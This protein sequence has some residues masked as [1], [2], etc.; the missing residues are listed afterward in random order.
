[1]FWE[2]IQIRNSVNHANDI[3][4]K[5][6]L[7]PFVRFLQERLENDAS[8]SP[9]L[10]FTLALME[11]ARATHGAL[12]VD[13]VQEYEA[14]L[15]SVRYLTQSLAESTD[16]IWALGYPVPD[17]AFFGT[18]SFLKKNSM[19]LEPYTALFQHPYEYD[20]DNRLLYLLILERF[21]DIPAMD[22]RLLY[23]VEEYGVT[24]YYQLEIDFSFVD[25]EPIGDLP[26]LD[27]SAFRDREI[28]SVEDLQPLLVLL[29]PRQFS[30]NGFSVLRFVKKNRELTEERLQLL[31]SN[32]HT[33][34][35]TDFFTELREIMMTALDSR[36]IQTSFFPMLE[37]NGFPVL[38]TDYSKDSIFFSDLIAREREQCA[39]GIFEF[40]KNPH[41]IAFGVE[42]G[43][44]TEDP[45]VIGLLQSADLKGYVCY[46]LKHNK[47]LVGFLEL[48]T[49]GEDRLGKD[50]VMKMKPFLPYLAQIAYEL[51]I[52]F[53][54]RL[55]QVILRNYTALQPAVQWRF[56]QVAARYL[57]DQ[58]LERDNL[59]LEQVV[60]PDV[61]PVYGAIDIK[62]ST[63]LRNA[64][65][66]EDGMKQIKR[67]E[68]LLATMKSNQLHIDPLFT[69]KIVE[70]KNWLNGVHVDR[71]L[72][73]IQ[74]FFYKEMPLFLAEAKSLFVNDE[75]AENLIDFASFN[76]DRLSSRK[77]D[78]F[79]ISLQ[80]MNGLIKTELEEL[81]LFVQRS[82]PSYFESFRTDGVEY[83]MYIGQSITPTQVF[84]NAILTAVRKQ[85]IVSMARIAQKSKRLRDNLSVPL[86]TTQLIFIHPHEIDISFRLDEKR[87]DVDGGYNVRYQVIKKRIDKALIRHSD[88]RL[89]KPD[90]IAI[91]YS[92]MAMEEELKN[93]LAEIAALG[94][95]SPNIEFVQLEDLQGVI[96]LRAMR[97][98]VILD[99]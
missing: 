57:G 67:L 99:Q 2:K 87:F 42:K 64:S 83:D 98:D 40:L 52:I 95:I 82:F 50:A 79:E 86:Q 12:D 27:M 51:V 23:T 75:D 46:P 30:F 92:T 61:Y 4:F 43:L 26:V 91:V 6:S 55:D 80:K 1:M 16:E 72:L 29:D 66:R 48:Y 44:D 11:K 74:S 38:K 21:Y 73:D 5:L 39:S 63:R 34:K 56:N 89:V 77:M 32:L 62:D 49:R 71:Y 35:L 90:S 94:Y 14:V 88:E 69:D 17:Y 15:E 54:Q 25:V 68:D 45:V 84:D 22:A 85:Q 53:K 20:F 37:L 41:T 47:T 19:A 76:E 33:Y 70:V 9:I 8:G 65:Q 31:I 3:T 13:N 10:Q 58:T 7:D 59:G 81:N 60:F 36:V 93:S 28:N 24:Q 96:E 97:V 78:A 18:D